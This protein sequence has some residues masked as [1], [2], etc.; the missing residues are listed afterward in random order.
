[1]KIWSI[2]P[3]ETVYFVHLKWGNVVN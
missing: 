2:D 3:L 1:V